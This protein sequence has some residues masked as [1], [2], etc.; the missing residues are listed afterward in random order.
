MFAQD[1]IDLLRRSGID[2]ERHEKEGID[3]NHF[4]ELLISSGVVLNDEIKWISFHSGYDFGYLLKVL[5]C[6][7]MPLEESEF[8]EM[9]NLYFPCIYD[10]KYLM[11]SCKNLKGGLQDVA[12]DLKV[13]RVGPQHQAGSDSLLTSITFFKMRQV[14]FFV[15]CT[16]FFA[17]VPILSSYAVGTEAFLI[18]PMSLLHT[19]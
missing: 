11:K 10:I 7:S 3:V 6:N 17:T 8:F 4:G 2:F 9:L 14:P 5:S 12:D 19:S 18:G 15:P 16:L 13:E 1:S